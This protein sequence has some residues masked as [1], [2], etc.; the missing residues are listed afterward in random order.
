MHRQISVSALQT[1]KKELLKGE[2]MRIRKALLSDFEKILKIY[3]AA[4]AFMRECGNPDQWGE[5]YPP[6]EL[7]KEDIA[8]GA[9]RVVCE[10]N[11][12]LAVFYTAYG[13]DSTYDRIYEGSWGT[14]EPYGIIHR[15][16]VSPTARGRGVAAFIFAQMLKEHGSLR[17]DTHADN[18]PMQKA[19]EKAGFALRGKI[20]IENPDGLAYAEKKNAERL[21]YDVSVR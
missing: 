16:A 5:G 9:C 1:V 17:I 8:V 21:A 15:V 6:S 7:I 19:L 12:P 13:T 2:K 11:E 18:K 4:R 10:G 3:A 20:Y 14:A